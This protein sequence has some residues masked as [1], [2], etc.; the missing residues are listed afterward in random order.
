MR[1]LPLTQDDRAD[2][3]ARI[4]VQ[5]IDDLF[6]DMPADKLLRE[7][8]PTAAAKTELEVERILS[9]MAARN[10]AAGAVPFFRRLRRLQAP[11]ARR[12]SII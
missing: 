7:P 11:R 9:Q 3:L 1:Y 8:L 4:G 2:M 6:A 5:N 12:P 10:V